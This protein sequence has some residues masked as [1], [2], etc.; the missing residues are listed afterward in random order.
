LF[1]ALTEHVQP[2]ISDEQ[3]AEAY[4]CMLTAR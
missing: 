3:I 2:V 4:A 1:E